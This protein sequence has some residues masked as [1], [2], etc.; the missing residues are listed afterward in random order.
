[1]ILDSAGLWNRIRQALGLTGAPEIARKLGLSKQSVYLW[2]KGKMPGLDTL[3]VIAESSNVSLDWLLTGRGSK[4]LGAPENSRI[5]GDTFSVYLGEAERRVLRERAT[6]AG[7]TPDAEVR[8]IVLEWM[9]ERGYIRDAVTPADLIFFGED[10]PE[11]VSMRLL[12]E[13]A[14]GRPI[15]V[16]EQEEMVMVA[17]DFKVKGRDH[18]VLRVRGDSMV[19]EGIFDKDLVICYKSSEA[20]DGQTVVA[21]I[22][23]DSATVKR[24][25]RDRDKV[26]L[27]PANPRYEAVV[28]PADRVVIQGIVVGVQRRT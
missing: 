10:V 27:E 16:F 25:H 23:G 20:R 2:E 14:A 12:G 6:E 19:E 26:R 22:D 28:L 11:L 5:A 4:L 3:A 17:Q 7:R 21:L 8:E 13:V 1:M 15:A 9:I 24:F 18:F